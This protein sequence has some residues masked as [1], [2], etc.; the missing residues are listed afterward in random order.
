MVPDKSRKRTAI[1]TPA[2]PGAKNRTYR[3][4][5]ACNCA[6]NQRIFATFGILDR[7]GCQLLPDRSIPCSSNVCYQ[8]IPFDLIFQRAILARSLKPREEVTWQK[9]KRTLRR[10]LLRN[11]SA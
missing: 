6:G 7:V 10:G 8:L 3:S 11:H 9:F 5:D 4:L 2:Q 1:Q